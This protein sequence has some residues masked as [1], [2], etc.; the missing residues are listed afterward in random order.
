MEVEQTG[1]DVYSIQVFSVFCLQNEQILK[2][3]VVNSDKLQ[4]DL[5]TA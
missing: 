4:L 5:M 2:R 3:R 1:N